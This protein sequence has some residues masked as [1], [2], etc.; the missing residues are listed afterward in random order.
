VWIVGA[1][2]KAV[3]TS[4]HPTVSGHVRVVARATQTSTKKKC[5]DPRM[6]RPEEEEAMKKFELVIAGGGLTAARAI[7][8]YREAGG[9]GR[10][11]AGQG[12]EDRLDQSRRLS[13]REATD[14]DRRP[15]TAPQGAGCPSPGVYLLRT[16]HDSDVIRERAQTAEHAVVA[17]GGFI[18]ME[19][20]P[21]CDSPGSRSA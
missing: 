17:G 5:V 4:A 6:S 11:R 10:H 18:G 21:R 3:L 7:R 15:P 20:A 2:G 16:L 14:R 9:R 13:V 1:A 19:V 8:S 12:H